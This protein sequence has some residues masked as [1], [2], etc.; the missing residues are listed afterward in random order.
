MGADRAREA[1]DQL[2]GQV[3]AAMESGP[4]EWTRPWSG[5]TLPANGTTGR[6]YSGANIL[7]LTRRASDR[8]YGS[9]RWA[10]F[11]QWREAGCS[12]RKG[13]RSAVV[14][15]FRPIEVRDDTSDDPTATKRVP[16]LRYSSVFAAEQV[17]G[18]LAEQ[19]RA[20]R[21]G[22]PAADARA[23]AWFAAVGAELRT[24]IA[25]AH[26]SRVGDTIVLPPRTSFR[27]AAG[28]YSTVAHEHVHWAGA[29]HRLDRAKGAMF[30]DDVYAREELIAELGAVFVTAHLGIVHEPDPQSAA[31]LAHWA[32]HLKQRPRDLWGVVGEA[33][34]AFDYLDGL[35]TAS[36]AGDTDASRAVAA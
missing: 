30:G 18:D 29:P 33:S 27:D 14:V 19:L 4:G 34:A 24:G 6:R 21:A 1:L 16:M 12:V 35:A 8:G 15:F 3:I 9:N 26:Y 17:D 10:T 2:V 25:S 28:W 23:D 7:G 22:G 5:L 20:P 36:D 13:E 11:Q 31:Y 32:G